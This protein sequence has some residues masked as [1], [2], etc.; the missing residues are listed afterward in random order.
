MH[1]TDGPI[2]KRANG[3]WE[4][5]PDGSFTMIIKRI[6]DAGR[7]ATEATNMG[8][9][10]FEVERVFRGDLTVIGE[11]V[12]VSGS[13]HIEDDLLGDREVGFFNLIETTAAKYGQAPDDGFPPAGN[14]V[15][16]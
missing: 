14:R 6:F 8:M 5:T 7:E 15:S 11:T 3:V 1:E 10:E 12:A 4:Q 16:V 13:I 9:F 2:F